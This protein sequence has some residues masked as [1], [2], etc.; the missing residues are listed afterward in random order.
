[1]INIKLS[2]QWNDIKLTP[3][4]RARR[5]KLKWNSEQG[6]RLSFPSNLLNRSLNNIFISPKSIQ[7]ELELF[8]ESNLSW[9]QSYREKTL[10]I[11]P[12][13]KKIIIP[14]NHPK[15]QH[16]QIIWKIGT[17]CHKTE[18]ATSLYKNQ[19]RIYSPTSEEIY[20]EVSQQKLKK[21]FQNLEKKEALKVLEPRIRTFADSKGLQLIN[22]TC[23][24]MK[25][26]WGSCSSKKNINLNA[27]IIRLPIE[28]QNY[29]LWHELAHL[30]QPNHSHLFWNLLETWYPGAQKLD[31]KLNQYHINL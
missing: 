24:Q 31:K 23:K 6:F 22:V 26:R 3:H 11:L 5:F 18:F 12:K 25:T 19:L 13:T 14:E 10:N 27:Q 7:K 20:S 1:M 4:S 28:L 2:H 8:L 30:I 9:I 29:V 15:F 17:S 16:F 21:A